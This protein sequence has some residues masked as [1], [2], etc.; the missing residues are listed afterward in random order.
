MLDLIE[1]VRT[2]TAEGEAALEADPKTQDAV[3]HDLEFGLTSNR[4]RG[5]AST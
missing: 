1:R 2:Y 5:R 4:H 3:L